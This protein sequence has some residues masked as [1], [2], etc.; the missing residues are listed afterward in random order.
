MDQ[1]RHRPLISFCTM[2]RN[3]DYVPDF[4]Y[5]L[6]TSVNCMA[7]T[8]A[9]L[10]RLDDVEFVVADWASNPPMCETFLL[11]EEAARISRFVYVSREAV[12]EVTNGTG[13]F[14]AAIAQNVS[15]RHALGGFVCMMPADTFLPACCMERLLGLLDNPVSLGFD[16]GKVYWQIPRLGAPWDLV[17]DRPS[18]AQWD[19]LIA[20][21]SASWLDGEEI[22]ALPSG[23]GAGMLII[24]RAIL[25]MWGGACEK[26]VAWGG[27]DMEQLDRYGRRFDYLDT[28]GLGV[29]SI[30]MEHPPQSVS[31]VA[32]ETDYEKRTITFADPDEGKDAL[33]WGLPDRTFSV[34]AAR[35]VGELGHAETLAG[36][37]GED[38]GRSDPSFPDRVSSCLRSDELA[39][40]IKVFCERFDL[41]PPAFR[42]GCPGN[43]LLADRTLLF[44]L[45]AL[46]KALP[47]RGCCV[48]GEH[49]GHVLSLL[50]SFFPGS[51]LCTLVECSG[52]VPWNSAWTAVVRNLYQFA[53]FR[54]RARVVNGQMGSAWKRLK[55]M[56]TLPARYDVVVL[57]AD[58]IGGLP[59]CWYA[60]LA[61]MVSEPGGI[62]V[63]GGGDSS[64]LEQVVSQLKRHLP[65]LVAVVADDSTAAFLRVRD[66]DA[67]SAC[68]VVSC[69]ELGA[70]LDHRDIN[71]SL[72]W[73][74]A[75][76]ILHPGRYFLPGIRRRLGW[77]G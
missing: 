55:A 3:D 62:L 70:G 57:F 50:A 69:A 40:L 60:E 46:G 38:G 64:S 14:H 44:S 23:G 58:R 17:R 7:Q 25:D 34:Q 27:Q 29:W 16:V 43:L 52:D 67:A 26:M 15:M 65:G 45:G 76:C 18:P 66:P 56:A 13:R 22:R 35:A 11:S 54:G 59:D 30:H 61:G 36:G 53:K 39:T 49:P 12:D 41:A 9:R 31:I 1:Q 74:I 5:R 73:R 19:R 75:R 72:W 33:V 2:G 37:T 47:M 51:T 48:V 21:S 24:P 20:V 4:R 68:A 71:A 28:F 32:R 42:S 77:R 10:G 63:K 8:L 6:T